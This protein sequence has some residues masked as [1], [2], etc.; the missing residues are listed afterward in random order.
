MKNKVERSCRWCGSGMHENENFK[1]CPTC[2]RHQNRVLGNTQLTTIFFAVLA[3]IFTVIQSIILFNSFEREK[4]LNEK[5]YKIELNRKNCLSIVDN[6]EN[7]V[8]SEKLYGVERDVD[9]VVE[10]HEAD[11]IPIEDLL[12]LFEASKIRIENIV[13]PSDW[14]GCE[15][16]I[17]QFLES[18]SKQQIVLSVN[19]TI[20]KYKSF[21]SVTNIASTAQSDDP[22]ENEKYRRAADKLSKKIKK[23]N[24]ILRKVLELNRAYNK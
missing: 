14:P 10:S 20:E 17:E 24:K 22:T 8:R 11:D 12:G 13:K 15:R 1:V 18:E 5:D 6:L 7:E 16:D 9:K 19:R 4:V 21:L 2:H 23:Y 3:A